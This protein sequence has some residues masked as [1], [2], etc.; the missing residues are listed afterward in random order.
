MKTNLILKNVCDTCLYRIDECHSTRLSLNLDPE[1]ECTD[2]LKDPS[3]PT[4]IPLPD[5]VPPDEKTL[6]PEE[7]F[8]I[9]KECFINYLSSFLTQFANEVTNK[10]L[11]PIQKLRLRGLL[12]LDSHALLFAIQHGIHPITGC[13]WDITNLRSKHKLNTLIKRNNNMITYLKD[14]QEHHR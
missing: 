1:V 6:S 7:E 14:N 8:L 5:Y 13:K 11:T 10:P 2:Y 4:S 12:E 9:Y 3:T